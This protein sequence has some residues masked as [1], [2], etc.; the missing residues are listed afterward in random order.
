MDNKKQ[1]IF[2]FNY[3]S[4]NLA[5]TIEILARNNHSN[6]Q[7]TWFDWTG[8]F[9]KTLEFPFADRIHNKLIRQKISKSK[10]CNQ[11]FPTQEFDLNAS[12]IRDSIGSDRA[13]KNLA[14]EVAYLEL[15]A[16]QRD[17]SPCKKHFAKKLESFEETF[18]KTYRAAHEVL[19]L[20]GYNQ[21]ILYNGRFLQERAVWEACLKLEIPVIFF[22]K[23][24]PNWINRFY[25]FNEATHS[26]SYRSSIMNCFGNGLEKNEPRLFDRVGKKWFEDREQGISQKY[27]RNQKKGKFLDLPNRYV[28]FFH[29]SED[30]LLTSDLLSDYWGNQR[31]AL[32]KLIEVITS[33]T[34]LHLVIR[35]HPNLLYKSRRE[36]RSWEEIGRNFENAN[37]S[38]VF[39][40]SESDVDSY[41]LIRGSL[42]VVTVGSTIGVEAAFLKKRSILL[43]RAF[44]EKMKITSN[45]ESKEEL[46]DLLVKPAPVL[47]LNKARHN[48]LKYAAF[49]ELGGEVFAVVK[50]SEGRIG[51]T[52]TFESLQLN[53]S[54]ISSI[55]MRLDSLLRRINHKYRAAEN[56][57]S[58]CVF[59]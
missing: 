43:G 42:A 45:P 50:T 56:C 40:D 15:I 19:L 36:I 31:D 3:Q 49:H 17:S 5:T 1:A 41:N 51:N 52:Y 46:M 6:F 7:F 35:M 32:E 24:N 57:D 25:L 14:T 22:E 13:L 54:K 20:G 12:N 26:P 48:S 39:I 33:H 47:E 21:V 2:S 44:H 30:E 9:V 53:L 23:F 8:K 55:L 11:F 10:F 59:N 29:S 28:V 34:D 58:N 37:Q 38:I 18:V 16:V 27:T 4:W